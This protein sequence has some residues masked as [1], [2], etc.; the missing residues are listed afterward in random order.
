[1][2]SRLQP[3][4]DAPFWVQFNFPSSQVHSYFISH[5]VKQQHRKEYTLFGYHRKLSKTELQKGKAERTWRRAWCLWRTTGW[6]WNSLKKQSSTLPIW[7]LLIKKRMLLATAWHCDTW[8]LSLS[9][10]PTT[11]WRPHQKLSQ[12]HWPLQGPS[13][14][15][16]QHSPAL[17][18]AKSVA[19]PSLVLRIAFPCVNVPLLRYRLPSITAFQQD[20]VCH[21]YDTVT[22][23]LSYSWI[24]NCWE[25]L[26]NRILWVLSAS[27]M[28]SES[29]NAL[30]FFWKVLLPFILDNKTF[31]VTATPFTEWDPKC[32]RPDGRILARE[33]S[34]KIKWSK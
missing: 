8:G 19:V 2:T 32:V 29:N 26:G 23:C 1:M 30:V 33:S 4:C 16:S 22:T 12:P 3:K 5:V 6:A 11:L 25:S 15:Y 31:W 13:L 28:R 14:L 24:M 27:P 34:Q 7:V 21:R 17:E 20:A 10:V 9:S 18:E